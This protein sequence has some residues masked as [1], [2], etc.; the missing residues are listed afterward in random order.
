MNN[1]IVTYFLEHNYS[2]TPR[3]ELLNYPEG[4]TWR[5]LQKRFD[6]HYRHDNLKFYNLGS[7]IP[8]KAGE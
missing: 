6:P 8:L 4:L 7:E 3:F 1:Y 5:Q 2:R